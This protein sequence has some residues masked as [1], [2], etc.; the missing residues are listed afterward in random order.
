MK[1]KKGK[2]RNKGRGI[3]K[4][5]EKEGTK[6]DKTLKLEKKRRR[7]MR[8]NYRFRMLKCMKKNRKQKKQESGA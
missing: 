8:G 7:K 2:R 6:R 4:R 5:R 1:R 3:R